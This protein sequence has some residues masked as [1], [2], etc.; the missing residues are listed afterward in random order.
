MHGDA[1]PSTVGFIFGL[2]AATAVYFTV[3]GPEEEP[4]TCEELRQEEW[5]HLKCFSQQPACK[6]AGYQ[7]Y[8]RYRA[9][10]AAAKQCPPDN[11]E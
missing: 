6:I 10:S 11:F 3:E 8:V 9:V 7:T 2:F 5:S 4:P 1:I